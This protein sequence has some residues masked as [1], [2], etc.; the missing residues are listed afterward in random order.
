MVWRK[1]NKKMA[2]R[3]LVLDASVIIKWFTQEEKREEA[4]NLREN[5]INGGGLPYFI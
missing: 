1:R 4:I 5:Y 2:Q 3:T